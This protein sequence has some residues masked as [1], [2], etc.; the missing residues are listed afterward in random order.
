L[1]E[2]RPEASDLF[3]QATLRHTKMSIAASVY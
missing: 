2:P 3:F 1:L